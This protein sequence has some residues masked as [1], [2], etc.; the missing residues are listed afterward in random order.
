LQTLTAEKIAAKK[1]Q[2]CWFQWL[3]WQMLS[4][5]IFTIV[6]NYMP[7]ECSLAI[8]VN[9]SSVLVTSLSKH[10]VCR[11]QSSFAFAHYQCF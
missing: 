5:R 2:V 11:F 1:V 6:F 8:S 9:S 10:C 3:K 4:E 7:Q